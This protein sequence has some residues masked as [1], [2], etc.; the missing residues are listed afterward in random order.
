M[1][2][3]AYNNEYSD[4]IEIEKFLV[5]MWTGAD[6]SVAMRILYIDLKIENKY[7]LLYIV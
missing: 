7:I 5:E 6:L 3:V 1:F 2:V 4:W